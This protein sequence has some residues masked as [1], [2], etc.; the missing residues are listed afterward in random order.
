MLKG[1]WSCSS[2]KLFWCHGIQLPECISLE[3]GSTESVGYFICANT[4]SGDTI[5]QRYQPMLG[6]SQQFYDR[7]SDKKY[8]P[9]MTDPFTH[10]NLYYTAAIITT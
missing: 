3:I 10:A 4:Q 8:K 2:G 7:S 1:R 6:G 5:Y 9:C